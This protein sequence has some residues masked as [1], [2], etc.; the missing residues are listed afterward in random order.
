MRATGILLRESLLNPRYIHDILQVTLAALRM[1]RDLKYPISNRL[2]SA[3]DARILIKDTFIGTR[4]ETF[5]VV[6]SYYGHV[7][8]SHDS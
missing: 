2:P 5:E 7:K 6:N 8:Y 1:R 3:C 4:P